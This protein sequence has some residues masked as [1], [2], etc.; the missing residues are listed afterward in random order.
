MKVIYMCTFTCN[1]AISSVDSVN[2]L[3]I[4]LDSPSS[5]SPSPRCVLHSSSNT[6]STRVITQ[7]SVPLCSTSKTP[8][9]AEVL[10]LLLLM[11]MMMGPRALCTLVLVCLHRSAAHLRE[12][13]C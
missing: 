5:S 10:L 12:G 2:V 1:A 4:V 3:Y 8:C 6:S 7:V 13:C 9:C 11:M